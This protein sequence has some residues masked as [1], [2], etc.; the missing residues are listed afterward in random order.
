VFL[1]YAASRHSQPDAD[2]DCDSQ[3]N[4]NH[5]S[6][7]HAD[8]ERWLPEPHPVS[9]SDVDGHSYRHAD[10]SADAK[11]YGDRCAQCNSDTFA[12]PGSGV[13][14]LDAAAG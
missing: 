10:S 12:F 13:E 11:S 4:S 1:A 3:S 14:Y 6:Y 7:G 8:A 2:C 5:L 9:H